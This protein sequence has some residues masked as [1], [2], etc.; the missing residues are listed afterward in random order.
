M[1]LKKK[2]KFEKNKFHET[3]ERRTEHLDL[4]KVTKA[5]KIIPSNSGQHTSSKILFRRAS[6][7]PKVIYGKKTIPD[8]IPKKNPPI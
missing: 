2:V 3:I 6:H 8:T 7:C 5:S 1:K 4:Q